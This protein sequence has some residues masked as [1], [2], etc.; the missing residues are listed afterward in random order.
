VKSL[1]ENDSEVYVCVLPTVILVV[2]CTDNR[3]VLKQQLAEFNKRVRISVTCNTM[4]D[5]VQDRMEELTYAV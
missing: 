2:G 4:R 5:V 3:P 1:Q